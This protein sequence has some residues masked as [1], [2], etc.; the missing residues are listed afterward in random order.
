VPPTNEER[1]DVEVY[2]WM[3]EPPVSYFAYVD[4]IAPGEVVTN[5]T[6]R[7]LGHI[8]SCGSIWKSNFGD[9]RQ[10]FTVEGTNG[11]TYSAT[12]Y[13]DSGTYCRM[14]AVK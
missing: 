1:S 11:I 8:T 7:T 13:I 14:R 5:F 4:K 10:H 2:E 12:A 6:G 3:T 9:R